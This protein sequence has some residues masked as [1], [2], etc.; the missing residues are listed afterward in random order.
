M[1]KCFCD[2]CGLEINPDTENA[3]AHSGR[4]VPYANVQISVCN[5]DRKLDCVSYF[6]LLLFENCK[7]ELLESLSLI[8]KPEGTND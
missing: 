2:K 8:S 7:K 3:F 1:L 4:I 5:N 6:N